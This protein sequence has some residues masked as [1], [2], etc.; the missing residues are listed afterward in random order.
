MRLTSFYQY[1]KGQLALTGWIG[2]GE[3]ILASNSL[4]TNVIKL[5]GVDIIF[6]LHFNESYNHDH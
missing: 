6:C 5:I 2:E 3:Q 1:Y 4:K